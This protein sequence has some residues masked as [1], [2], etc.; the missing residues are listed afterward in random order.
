MQIDQMHIC[1]ECSHK[2]DLTIT[3]GDPPF[4]SPEECP[5]CNREID[6]EEVEYEIESED[7]IECER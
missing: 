7:E 3:L 6:Q 1:P 4:F 5:E 2:F